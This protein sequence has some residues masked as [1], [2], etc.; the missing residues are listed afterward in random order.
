MNS[1]IT[2]LTI[3][4]CLFFLP[5]VSMADM[6]GLNY[7]LNSP[8]SVIKHGEPISYGIGS[9]SVLSGQ[10]A[11]AFEEVYM[12]QNI[13]DN[14]EVGLSF[15]RRRLLKL[16]IQAIAFSSENSGY[17][18]YIGVGSQNM[19]W[20][21]FDMPQTTTVIGPF[22]NYTFLS[23][24]T[25]TRYNMG[26]TKNLNSLD[27]T[28]LFSMEQ[29]IFLGTFFWGWD[30]V[31]DNIGVSSKLHGIP[32]FMAVRIFDE[33]NETTYLGTAGVHFT[34]SNSV[35]R[36]VAKIFGKKQPYKPSN[37]D[38]PAY[39]NPKV[40]VSY[41]VDQAMKQ[42]YEHYYNGDLEQALHSY[43]LVTTEFPRSALAHNRLGTIYFQLGKKRKA[44]KSWKKS[45]ALDPKNKDLN[46]FV[47][48]MQSEIAEE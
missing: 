37:P 24:I 5:T 21:S 44:M 27:A 17:A 11:R 45:L 33:E 41:T 4:V 18:H 42:G 3:V 26:F 34:G 7:F 35:S 2:R 14:V 13:W 25:N 31:A 28:L 20:K 23:H 22:V 6:G 12:F 15:D 47:E 29:K 43:L 32:F 16:H 1:F 10:E 46:A 48:R 40:Q 30:G 8:S 36:F 38:A 9:T 19:G 39:R